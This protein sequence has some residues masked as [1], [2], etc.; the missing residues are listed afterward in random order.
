MKHSLIRD[1]CATCSYLNIKKEK[2]V[3]SDNS[4]VKSQAS[5]LQSWC[6]WTILHSQ[7]WDKKQI[8]NVIVVNTWALFMA[9]FLSTSLDC[10]PIQTNTL[11]GKNQNTRIKRGF[12]KLNNCTWSWLNAKKSYLMSCVKDHYIITCQIILWNKNNKS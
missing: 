7:N 6:T 5:D 10:G 4:W 3:V 9:I 1:K 11:I 2:Q 12:M 8:F